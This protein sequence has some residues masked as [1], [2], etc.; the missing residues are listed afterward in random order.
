MI[1]RLYRIGEKR[2]NG[3]GIAVQAQKRVKPCGISGLP[4]FFEESKHPSVSTTKKG[5]PFDQCHLDINHQ[6]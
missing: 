2:S 4:A 6:V 1:P 3:F 5:Q